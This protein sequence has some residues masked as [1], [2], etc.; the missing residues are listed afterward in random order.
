[1]FGISNITVLGG[2]VGDSKVFISQAN[3]FSLY[4]FLTNHWSKIVGF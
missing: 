4:Y 3:M 1:M 2:K